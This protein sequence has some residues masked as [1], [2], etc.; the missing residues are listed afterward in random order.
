MD[1]SNATPKKIFIVEDDTL[2]R[3]LYMDVLQAEGFSIDFAEDGQIAYEKLSQGG[4]DLVLLDIMLP[5]MDGI[6]I[7]EK[8]KANPPAHP[9]KAILVLS[10]LGQES[11]IASAIDKG[12]RGYM[13][14][15]DYT[16]DKF[17][18]EVK[19]YISEN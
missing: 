1:Q 16:P 11:I 4:F 10:N 5:K 19:R 18:S 13:I 2:L 7:L 3:E 9:I 17:L 8:L 14:K 6:Q 12:A 15:S